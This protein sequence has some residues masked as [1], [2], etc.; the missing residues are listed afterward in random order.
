MNLIKLSQERMNYIVLN[1]DTR[2]RIINIY[3]YISFYNILYVYRFNIAVEF[4]KF[5]NKLF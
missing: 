1:E 4:E 3:L 2:D 5:D